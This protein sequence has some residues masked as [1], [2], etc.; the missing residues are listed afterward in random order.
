[1]FCWLGIVFWSGYCSFSDSFTPRV[2][3]YFW[4][5]NSRL[6]QDFF[7][8]QWFLFPDTLLSNRWSKETLKKLRKQ[9]QR[10][11]HDALQTYGRDWIRFD[12]K[13]KLLIKH[14]LVALKNPNLKNFLPFMQTSSPFSKL[15]YRSGK[16]LGKFQDFF[17]KNSKLCT[18]P[19]TRNTKK[20]SFKGTSLLPYGHA[21]QSV[22]VLPGWRS[23]ET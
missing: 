23:S 17:F 18:N 12:Q 16:L 3:T 6:L 9:T 19:A 7:Q 13:K 14:L 21:W 11:F 1:M 20:L 15:F 4:I 8:K 5:Q 22:G 2:G 10:F